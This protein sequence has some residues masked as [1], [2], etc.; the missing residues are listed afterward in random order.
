[1]G[2]VRRDAKQKI[3]DYLNDKHPQAPGLHYTCWSGGLA[4]QTGGG[5]TS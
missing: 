1:M 2:V 4:G 3:H 5:L